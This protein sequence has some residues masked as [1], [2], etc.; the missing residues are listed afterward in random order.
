MKY[1]INAMFFK[2][3]A[4]YPRIKCFD[5]YVIKPTLK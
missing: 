5:G 1:M 2:N 3:V 4:I